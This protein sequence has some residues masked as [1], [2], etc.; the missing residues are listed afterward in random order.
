MKK[1]NVIQLKGE[2]PEAKIIGDYTVNGKILTFPFAGSGVVEIV[3]CEYSHI[4][5]VYKFGKKI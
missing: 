3:F 1:K 4:F 5:V 2:T